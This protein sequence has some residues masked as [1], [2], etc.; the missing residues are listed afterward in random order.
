M[1]IHDV[2]RVCVLAVLHYDIFHLN[3]LPKNVYVG[4]KKIT[5]FNIHCS[6]SKMTSSNNNLV[7]SLFSSWLFCEKYLEN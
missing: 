3:A 5:Q 4:S 2:T 1:E 6:S 7:F